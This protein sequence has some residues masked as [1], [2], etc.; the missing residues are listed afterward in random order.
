VCISNSLHHLE[1]PDKAFNELMRVLRPDGLV[2]IVEMY[3]DGIQTPAQ[4]THIAMHHWFSQID[5]LNKTYHRETYLKDELLKL[6]DT[7]PLKK[8]D[9]EDFYIPVDNPTDPEAINPMIKNV[10][11][12]IKKCE[13]IPE[14]HHICNE[15]PE[16]IE[17]IKTLGCVSASRLLI[18]GYKK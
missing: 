14:A 18:T 8:K 2:V 6:T 16:I 10:Q 3:K 15:G 1:H 12:W 11:E 7:L 13:S 5:T 9:I 17:Q 4:K